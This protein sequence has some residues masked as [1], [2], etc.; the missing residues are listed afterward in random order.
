MN[1]WKSWIG[2]RGDHVALP[3]VFLLAL[4]AGCGGGGGGGGGTRQPSLETPS[5]AV[6][7]VEVDEG[8]SGTTPAVFHVTLSTPGSEPVTARW[9]T[10]DG[11]ASADRDYRPTKGTFVIEPGNMD[12]VV[13]VDVLGDRRAESDETFFLVLESARGAD[14]EEVEARARATVRDN[15]DEEDTPEIGGGQDDTD[16]GGDGSTRTTITDGDDRGGR[17]KRNGRAKGHRERD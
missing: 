6:S 2:A 4:V 15:D 8:D 5:I 14:L 16:L 3:P 7:G 1:H 17:S 11:T 9:S 12:T 10:L 13:V